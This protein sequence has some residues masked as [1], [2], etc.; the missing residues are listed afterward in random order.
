VVPNVAVSFI[1]D[2]GAT[3]TSTS[4]TTNQQG[5]ATTTLTNTTSGVSKVT[6]KINGHSQTVDTTF[7]ADGGTATIVNG[8]LTITIDNAVANGTDTNAVQAKVTD[9]NGNV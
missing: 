5:L 1:A 7:V 2:N 3:V 4:A 9:A 8:D 6:A